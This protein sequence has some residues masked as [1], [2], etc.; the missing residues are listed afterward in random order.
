MPVEVPQR[1]LGGTLEELGG[2]IG[3]L[4]G[5]VE[6]PWKYLGDVL[7]MPES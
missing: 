7:E 2:L 5:S 1:C 4:G 6:E 3:V